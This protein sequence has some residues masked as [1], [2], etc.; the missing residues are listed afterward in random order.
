MHDWYIEVD[1]KP[2]KA[3]MEE[4]AKAFEDS[5]GRR[6]AQDTVGDISVSTV[7]LGIDHR[8]GG[9]GP[10]VLYE[11]MTFGGEQEIQ[12]RYTTR[13]KA[14]KGHNKVVKE[15]EDAWWLEQK[16]KE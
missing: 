8:L 4:A 12:Q 14:V 7:F 9:V 1:G 10:P 11:T 16:N 5:E 6:V 15:L 13:N 3:S 2:R